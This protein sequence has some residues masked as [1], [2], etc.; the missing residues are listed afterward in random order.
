MD[1]LK[2]FKE[3]LIDATVGLV[4]QY[5][6]KT[7]DL[8]KLEAT[9]FYIRLLQILRRQALVIML[10]LF[11]V[12]MVAAGIVI[13]PLALIALAPWSR[14]TKLVLALLI[15]I[16]DL[17]VPLFLLGYFLSEK[18]WMELTKSDELLDSVTKNK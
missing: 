1:F 11:L 12:V 16:A 17:G 14:E 18:K 2:R 8:V 5:Q 6:Q 3:L 15:G 13:V 7:M 4:K 9:A 10:G